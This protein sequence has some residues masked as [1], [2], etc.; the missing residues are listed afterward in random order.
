MEKAKEKKEKVVEA[1]K[2]FRKSILPV[3]FNPID[4]EL[5][6]FV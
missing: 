6:E 1:E 5:L 4:I 2:S 3:I